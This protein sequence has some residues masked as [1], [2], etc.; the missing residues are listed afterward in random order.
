MM[1]SFPFRAAAGPDN[2]DH[3]DLDEIRVLFD[4]LVPSRANEPPTFILDIKRGNRESLVHFQVDLQKLAEADLQRI[5]DLLTERPKGYRLTYEIAWLLG[6][7]L[8][9]EM[10]SSNPE[11]RQQKV[12]ELL[13]C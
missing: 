6:L 7:S 9:Q 11:A 4:W 8:E 3:P 1:I 10:P 12:R 5:H 2:L 13:L